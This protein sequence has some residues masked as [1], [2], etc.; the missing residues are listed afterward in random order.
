MGSGDGARETRLAGLEIVGW[1][2]DGACAPPP[3]VS[4]KCISD[5]RTAW[6]HL[7]IHSIRA[8]PPARSL[9]RRGSAGK[10]HCSTAKLGPK[11]DDTLEPTSSGRGPSTLA[12]LVAP[13]E[14]ACLRLT[15]ALNRRV[16]SRRHLL[17]LSVR[18]TAGQ[19]H[20]KRPP[21]GHRAGRFGAACSRHQSGWP[22]NRLGRHTAAP[23]KRRLEAED[24]NRGISCGQNKAEAECR[25][26]SAARLV[27]TG[28]PCRSRRAH[29]SQAKG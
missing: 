3:L 25:S 29:A 16:P 18:P 7:D 2:A 4:P 14:R 26:A 20:S 21:A 11:L 23:L 27:D 28:K 8:R 6:A 17:H 10:I 9:A 22:N 13:S 19:A 5:S 24:A 12:L 1:P 15:S